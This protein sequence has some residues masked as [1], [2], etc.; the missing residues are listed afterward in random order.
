MVSVNVVYSEDM[1]DKKLRSY[2]EK[3][4]RGI[5][6]PGLHVVTF[7]MDENNMLAVM[8][9]REY[10]AHLERGH[11]LTIIGLAK[12]HDEAV[13]MVGYICQNMIDIYG[14]LDRKLFQKEY[15][16]S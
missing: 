6:V 11:K 4:N 9:L 10:Y 14:S 1:A 8:S 2:V 15:G 3:I 16:I 12:D 7:G 13:T 5:K